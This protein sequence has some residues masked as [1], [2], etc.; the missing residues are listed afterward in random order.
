MKKFLSLVL[1][2]VMTMSLVTV[3]A[4]AAD[5]ADDSSINYTEAIDVISALDIVGGYSNNT[6]R[7]GNTLTRGAAAKII[8]NL[9]L[10]PTTANALRATTAP[11][12]DVPT[13]N[14]FAGYITYCAQQNIIGGYG[15]GTFRPS[16]TLSGFAFMKMLLGALGYD[17]EVE[18]FVGPNWSISVAKLATGIGLADDLNGAFDGSKAVTREEACL[19]AFNTL[20]TDMVE[21]GNKTSITVGGTDIVIGAGEA[22]KRTTNSNKSYNNDNDGI[23][24]FCEEYFKDLKLDDTADT[25]DFGRSARTWNWKNDKIGTFALTADAEYHKDVKVKDIYADLG[26]SQ[27]SLAFKVTVDGDDSYNDIT[28]TKSKSE[29]PD[30]DE[31]LAKQNSKELE[32]LVGNGSLIQVYY[33]NTVTPA[34]ARIAIINHYLMQVVGDYDEDD[35]ELVLDT[36]DGTMEY[37]FSDSKNKTLSSDDFAGL[38]EFEDEDYV[39]VTIAD[40]EIQSIASAEKVTATVTEYVLGDTVTA[41]GKDYSYA[42][43]AGDDRNDEDQDEGYELKED[44]D[45]YLDP[46]GYVIFADGVEA[47]GNYVYVAEFATSGNLTKNG[48]V[49]AYAYFA[50]GTEDEITINKVDGSKVTAADVDNVNHEV[51]GKGAGWYTYSEKTDGKFDLKKVSGGEADT[52]TGVI[53]DYSG[54]HTKI[55]NNSSKISEGTKST[56]FVVVNKNDDVKVYTGIKNV[57]DITATG[58]DAV[59]AVASEKNSS[60]AKYVFIDVDDGSV[61]GGNKSGDVIFFLELDKTGADADDDQYYRYKAIVTKDGKTSETKIRVDTDVSITDGTLYT[62]ISYNSKGYVTDVTEVDEAGYPFDDREDFT[63]KAADLSDAANMSY[64][65]NTLTLDGSDYYL[66][67][68][69]TIYTMRNLSKDVKTQ[70]AKQVTR[71]DFSASCVVWGVLNGDGE[72]TTL[73]I[74]GRNSK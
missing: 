8:C 64:K 41:G 15:D 9:I 24:Q 17:S 62:D 74:T 36:V 43:T 66:A 49:I 60:Y 51:D 67:D 13:D 25:D 46:Y 48:K 14:T 32:D 50:D 58:A 3:S 4:G 1:A 18:K 23:V 55:M 37:S 38:D 35:E 34:I 52:A 40:D 20:T 21:Y 2:L 61:K 56:V 12:P 59:V 28:L 65:N 16:N 63:T 45:L 30:C 5:F 69:Y 27:K 29:N 71:E 22:R 53:T 7:P 73:Y 19:Y 70:T 26:V 47:S 72:Y 33:D 31:K 57:P 42:L 39:V 68:G 11:F 6:F 54:E 44:Y 10:G